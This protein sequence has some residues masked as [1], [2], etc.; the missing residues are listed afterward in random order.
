MAETVVDDT[1]DDDTDVDDTDVDDTDIDDTGVDD[2]DVD[3]DNVDICPETSSGITTERG[4]G[5]GGDLLQY[6]QVWGEGCS[7]PDRPDTS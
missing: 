2:S 7:R 3:G 4:C 1:D 6:M 5:A